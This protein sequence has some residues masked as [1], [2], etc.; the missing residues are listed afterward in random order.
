MKPEQTL[1]IT[2]AG[3]TGNLEVRDPALLREA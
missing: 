3:A 2:Q 1:V